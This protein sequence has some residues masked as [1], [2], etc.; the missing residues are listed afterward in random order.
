MTSPMD[1]P[2]GYPSSGMLPGQIQSSP[3]YSH[4]PVSSLAAPGEQAALVNKPGK[5][6]DSM[7]LQ[8]TGAA[9]RRYQQAQKQQEGQDY[10]QQDS[11]GQHA[12]LQA[13]EQQQ[14]REEIGLRFYGDSTSTGE[15]TEILKHVLWEIAALRLPY[16]AF[17]CTDEAVISGLT[18]L[19]REIDMRSMLFIT[20]S[21]EVSTNL[22]SY[23]QDRDAVL[24]AADLTSPN[25]LAT[26]H[27]LGALF[28][29][30]AHSPPIIALHC[31][32][33]LTPEEQH[34]FQL[35]ATKQLLHTGC[36]NVL[37][38]RSNRMWSHIAPSLAL[39]IEMTLTRVENNVARMSQQL[40][41]N[42]QALNVDMEYVENVESRYYKLLW[43]YVFRRVFIHFASCDTRLDQLE[44][45]QG[46]DNWVFESIIA[47]GRLGVTW[48]CY[49]STA[50]GPKVTRAMRVVGKSRIELVG[51]LETIY[52]EYRIISAIL[53]HPNIIRCYT[54]L[55]S[56]N[57][58]YFVM[59]DV[60]GKDL[61]QVMSSF[62]HQE[63]PESLINQ[64][65][66][67]VLCAISHCHRSRICHR[68]IRPEI[69]TV[70]KDGQIKLTDFTKAVPRKDV[71][72]LTTSAGVWPYAAPEA[73][74]PEAMYDGIAADMWSLGILLID[75]I[76]G[77][78]RLE[79]ALDRIQVEPSEVQHTW[80]TATEATKKAISTQE[81]YDLAAL[82][83]AQMRRF[84]G[85]YT[86]EGGGSS[87]SSM[88]VES[89][90]PK[91]L[92][93]FLALRTIGEPIRRL[94]ME[95]VTFDP[96]FRTSTIALQI[97]EAMVKFI[98][99]PVSTPPR[100]PALNTIHRQGGVTP[101]LVPARE[102][103]VRASP[104]S[105]V[106][107]AERSSPSD[108]TKNRSFAPSSFA[109][110]AKAQVT[111]TGTKQ[112]TVEAVSSHLT[113]SGSGRQHALSDKRADR[114]TSQSPTER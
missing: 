27:A 32:R 94:V 52:R 104:R 34:P 54:M 108:G 103:G 84:F 106:P 3:A 38:N 22:Y 6:V 16:F 85:A 105:D 111:T 42:Q 45:A 112:L 64:Y 98:P 36:D 46:V 30:Y 18:S 59:D 37:W 19:A 113:N 21:A 28:D 93:E 81:E 97:P 5:G 71:K 11:G 29:S 102:Q 91:T 50:K 7:Q 68:D 51:E 86:P 17:V 79:A 56:T 12:I 66:V 31:G 23:V 57:H 4:P 26:V 67:Q 110:G 40:Q 35:Q 24:V 100:S 55:H 87:S 2:E 90:E 44:T 69:V 20:S 53:R 47:E 77:P 8:L 99:S 92:K 73:L 33:K 80:P 114:H 88:A 60:S 14:Q 95:C 65:W 76:R 13:E 96:I 39:T 72:G 109:A 62:P 70:S 82:R 63:T 107:A 1:H 9:A 10:Q 43:Q 83:V 89:D 61:F 48:R 41:I 101:T 49:D 25:S 15:A 74:L 58:I 78:R 75:M